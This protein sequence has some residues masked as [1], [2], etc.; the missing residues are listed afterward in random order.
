MDLLRVENVSFQYPLR[1]GFAVRN[2]DL[3]VREGDF[4]LLTGGSGSGKTTLL[5]L[6]KKELSPAGERTGSICFKNKEVSE[7]TAEESAKGI[8]F[9]M[10]NPENQIVTDK[11]R[12]EL[13]FTLENLAVEPK[14]MRRRTA[15][16]AGYFGLAPYYESDTD[17][18]SGGLKQTL[19]LASVIAARPDLLLLD[20]P[21]SQLDP[22]A[23]SRFIL[24][25]K[26]LNTE[27]GITVVIAEHRLEELFPLADQVAVMEDG[28]L[29]FC[30]PPG[31]VTAKLRSSG[32]KA[33]LTESLPT[34]ARIYA[35]LEEGGNAPVSVKEG[36]S[37][38]ASRYDITDKTFPRE[39][40]TVPEEK[41]L[42]FK[43]I[44]F[45]YGDRKSVV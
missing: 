25:L 21:T 13:A 18:L 8:G 14:T 40:Y 33:G 2:A 37:Y 15:E 28:R 3:T 12:H 30:C 5:K 39:P 36:R 9:V 45:R 22:A 20:E 42:T 38:L 41:A 17:E 16:T 26:K 32:A 6:I 24:T 10:Q 23:A 35:A 11:V 4:V 1:D 31:E 19:N 43:N 27:F 7:L 34:A 29:L 44:R